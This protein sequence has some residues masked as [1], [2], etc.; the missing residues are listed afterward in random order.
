[1]PQTCVII[2]YPKKVK[3]L[4]LSEKVTTPLHQHNSRAHSWT[5]GSVQDPEPTLGPRAH[6][7]TQGSFKDSGHIQGPKAHSRTQGP[8]QG[9][10]L[11]IRGEVGVHNEWKP[12]FKVLLWHFSQKLKK[13]AKKWVSTMFKSLQLFNFG[14]LPPQMWVWEE[15]FS[16]EVSF[17]VDIS[18]SIE[19]YFC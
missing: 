8:L 19:W 17:F 18:F 1:M 4:T 6:S 16:V 12:A 11:T 9:P 3:K 13:S 5:Q 2:E 15:R 7:R 10:G 14:G